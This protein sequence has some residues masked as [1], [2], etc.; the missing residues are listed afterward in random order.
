M[1]CHLPV[2]KFIRALHRV[3]ARFALDSQF[4]TSTEDHIQLL[5]FA[6]KFIKRINA[7]LETSG[8]WTGS[9]FSITLFAVLV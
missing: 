9:P 1:S 4:A 8:S 7:M 2:V 5:T 3:A 6:L